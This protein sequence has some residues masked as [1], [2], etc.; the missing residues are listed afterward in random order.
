MY[1]KLIIRLILLINNIFHLLST[2]ITLLIIVIK[3]GI[4]FMRSPSDKLESQNKKGDES[5]RTK[6]STR[7]K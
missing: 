4:I 3:I 6:E 5:G 7:V 2:M 1:I